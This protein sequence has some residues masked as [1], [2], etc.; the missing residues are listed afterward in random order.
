MSPSISIIIATYNAS[1]TI[2]KC[3][4]S[5]FQQKD[6]SVEL[7]V[8]DGGSTDGTQAILSEYGSKI[9]AIISERD[10]GI[11][12]AWNKGIG[13]S[14]CKW[15]MFI[16]ADD[17]LEPDAIKKYRNFLTAT[18]TTGIDYICAKNSYVSKNGNVLKVFGAAWRWQ[19]FRRKMHLA[20][21]GSLHSRALFQEVGPYDMRFRICGDY[22]LLL[23]KRDQL[24]CLFLDSCIARMAIGG[25][26]YS[27][28]AISEAHQIRKLHSGLPPMILN[29]LY[30]WQVLLFWRY[31]LVH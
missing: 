22:E 9:D 5:I 8:I 29:M 16:G 12:D 13:K 2:R 15:I 20:H 3:L 26:S 25:A 28:K 14:H 18:D 27:M 4:E 7:L 1:K 21:V 30:I 10:N 11:Y 23:R 24:R 19:Q 6:G 31:R 17:T